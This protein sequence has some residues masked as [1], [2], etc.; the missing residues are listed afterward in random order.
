MDKNTQHAV[1]ALKHYFRLLIDA[2]HLHWSDLNDRDIESL[3][4]HLVGAAVE[5]A[6]GARIAAAAKAPTLAALQT[7]GLLPA[8]HVT[9]AEVWQAAQASYKR[10]SDFLYQRGRIP[11]SIRDISVVIDQEAAA[12][13]GNP[14][15]QPVPT[16]SREVSA[17]EFS[18]RLAASVADGHMDW[19]GED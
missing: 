12:L 19:G 18:S 3:V 10:I 6:E 13:P 1:A 5:E 17:E 16:T 4:A 15:T 14:N 7:A 9:A 2:T 11:E 8:P